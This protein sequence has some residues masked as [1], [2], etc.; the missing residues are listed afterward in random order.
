MKAGRSASLSKELLDLTA[1]NQRLLLVLSMVSLVVAFF[2]FLLTSTIK[3]L[4]GDL[5]ILVNIGALVSAG[6]IILSVATKGP[7]PII[8]SI[9]GIVL[10]HNAIILP[11][12]QISEGGE[13]I[14]RGHKVIWISYSSMTVEVA[15][16]MH[17][18]LG[19]SMV[20]FAM[21]I[22]HRPSTLFARNRPVPEEDEWSKYP[23]WNDNAVLADGRSEQAVPI[24]NMMTEQDRHLLW[25]YEFVLASIYGSLH[26]VRPEGMVPRDSTMLLRDR[27]TGRLYGK[28]RF[29]GFFV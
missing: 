5:M 29:G 4:P 15:G 24:R 28:A 1:R 2:G 16:V 23:H 13:E 27:G 8:V 19:I 7:V 26:L 11:L 9:L 3:I 22:A 6:F 10:L 20:V 21:I 25:R 14:L 12:Y 18:F 17:F